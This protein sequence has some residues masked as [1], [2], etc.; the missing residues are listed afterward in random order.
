MHP[1]V[2]Q[3][4]GPVNQRGDGLRMRWADEVAAAEPLEN[5]AWESLLKIKRQRIASH[6]RHVAPALL[7]C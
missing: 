6:S 3:I 5:R 7:L 1:Q 4:S 2:E